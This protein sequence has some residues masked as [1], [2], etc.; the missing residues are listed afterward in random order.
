MDQTEQKQNRI[1]KGIVIGIVLIILLTIFWPFVIV[2][3]GQRGVVTN[4]GKVS[5]VVHDE[6]LH[7]RIPI[8]QSV[9]KIN[10]RV[11]KDAVK[12]EAASKDLQDVNIDVVVNYHINPQRV[13]AVFQ[14][15]GDNED[16]FEK[17]IAPNTNEIVKASSAEFSAQDII[18]KRQQL[19]DNI[20]KR[21]IERL[22]TY[23]IILDDVSLT[24]VDFSTDFNKAIENKQI[25]Q[26]EAERARL[27]VEK[28][29]QEAEANRLS[30]TALTPEILQ[31]RFLE[32]WNG[33]LPLYYGGELPFLTI[34]R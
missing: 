4:F 27:L 8:A 23:G 6:G 29:R 32:K 28:A 22:I 11:Q 5:G 31:N 15:I 21:L 14:Q 25:A 2:G 9:K 13:N 18:Q 17:I 30:Q 26:Q 19:K 10:V 24:N 20:D 33:V 7:F 3:A 1:F 12:A 34:T 16:V